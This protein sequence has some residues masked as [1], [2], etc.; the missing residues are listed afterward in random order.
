MN[1][2]TMNTVKQMCQS[3]M[4]RW[5]NHILVRLLQRG[6][7][8]DDVERT[9]LSGEIIEQYPDDYPYP[10]CLILGV[11]DAKRHMHIVCGVSDVELWL[12]TAYYPDGEEWE[13]DLITRKG[14]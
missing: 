1:D 5:T 14:D 6:I 2:I 4:L 11:P 13:S 7:S 12:I 3:K 8:L 9:L 10:S